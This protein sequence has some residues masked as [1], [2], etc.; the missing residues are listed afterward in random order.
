MGSIVK[1]TIIVKNE[2]QD[3]VTSLVEDFDAEII[4]SD[5]L[6]AFIHYIL[7]IYTIQHHSS[8]E[9]ERIYLRC[10]LQYTPSQFPAILHLRG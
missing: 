8:D 10:V 4:T 1:N 2:I 6:A 7:P 3:Y 9:V 5:Q